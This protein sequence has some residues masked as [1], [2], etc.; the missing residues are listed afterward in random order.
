[1][2]GAASVHLPLKQSSLEWAINEMFSRKG[3]SL[4]SLNLNAFKLGREQCIT[5]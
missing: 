1:M 2:L 3:D 5:T 4:V